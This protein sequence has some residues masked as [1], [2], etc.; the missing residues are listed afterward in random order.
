MLATSGLNNV[1]NKMQLKS[2]LFNF[3][4]TKN[5]EFYF[6]MS[7]P[8]G[9]DAPVLSVLRYSRLGYP[10]ELLRIVSEAGQSTWQ[11]TQ[12]CLS[13]GEYYVVFEAAVGN[14][15]GSVVAIDNV[16]LLDDMCDPSVSSTKGTKGKL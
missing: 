3:S 10:L 14:Q 2:P 15:F 8:A 7:V 1:G 4:Q 6:S 12:L 16:Q 11:S 9:S 5:L 13:P